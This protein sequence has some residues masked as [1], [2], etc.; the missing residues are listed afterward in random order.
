M[1]ARRRAVSRIMAGLWPP[2]SSV[3]STRRSGERMGWC[4]G[5]EGF[6]FEWEVEK[7]RVVLEGKGRKR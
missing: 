3:V 2:S 6:V 7:R 5:R 1:G 4:W